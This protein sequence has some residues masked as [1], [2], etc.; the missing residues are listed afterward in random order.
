MDYART[1]YTMSIYLDTFAAIY[2]QE[3]FKIKKE[4]KYYTCVRLLAL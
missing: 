3:F 4:K 2:F 1:L